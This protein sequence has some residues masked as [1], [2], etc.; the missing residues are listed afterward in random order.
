MFVAWTDLQATVKTV[1]LARLIECT[2]AD[3]PDVSIGLRR[4]L[5]E[6]LAEQSG[7]AFVCPPQS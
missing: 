2:V 5:A 3:V 7:G 1:G 6:W 4:P